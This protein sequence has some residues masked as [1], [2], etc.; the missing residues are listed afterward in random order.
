MCLQSKINI[1][2]ILVAILVFANCL[3]VGLLVG[4]GPM[5][6]FNS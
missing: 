4:V 5:A 3:Q 1:K 2:N 6:N